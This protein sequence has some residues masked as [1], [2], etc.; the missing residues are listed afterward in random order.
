MTNLTEQD[1]EWLTNLVVASHNE[2]AQ[3][4]LEFNREIAIKISAQGEKVE[5]LYIML[6]RARTIR[7]FLGL[8]F[9]LVV[10]LGVVSGAVVGTQVLYYKLFGKA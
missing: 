1:K 9:K 2:R 10:S 6:T 3:T 5:E 4:Q 8:M 7:D